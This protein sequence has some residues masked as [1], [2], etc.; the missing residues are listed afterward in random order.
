MSNDKKCALCSGQGWLTVVDKYNMPIQ[1]QCKYCGGSG[2]LFDVS[3]NIAQQRLYYAKSQSAK[4]D[5][6]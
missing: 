3:A 6:V 2:K 1:S 5:C 4:A